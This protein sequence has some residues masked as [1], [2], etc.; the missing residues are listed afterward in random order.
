[1]KLKG[2]LKVIAGATLFV[3]GL[4]Q[5]NQFIDTSNETFAEKPN[6]Q[7]WK[8]QLEDP[9]TGELPKNIRAQELDFVSSKFPMGSRSEQL[10]WKNIGPYNIGGRTR[11]LAFDRTNPQ[12]IVAGSASG[13]IYRTED[14]GLTW[15]KVSTHEH[16]VSIS[17]IEQD[18]R[19]GKEK[20]WYA[21]TGEARGA[22][23]GAP[24]FSAHFGGDGVLISEDNGKTW[25][26]LGS[27]INDS[28]QRQ[29]S[30]D[31]TWK[32]LVDNQ[33]AQ[34]VLMLATTT[35]IYRS[36]D[37]GATWRNVSGSKQAGQEIDIAQTKSGV[38]YAYIN[39]GIGS[40]GLFRSTDGKNFNLVHALT[41]SLG[42]GIIGLNPQNE[43]A[44]Y[45][46]C[47][48][49]GTGMISEFLGRNGYHSLFKYYYRSG[50]GSGAG[51]QLI[52]L[53]QNLPK[54][55]WPFDDYHSQT[56]YCMDIKVSPHDS[57]L[58]ALSGVNLNISHDGFS[59]PNLAKF[60][61][62]YYHKVDTPF[63]QIYPNHHP[64]LQIT[65]FHPT[66][67]KVMMTGSDGGIH[68]TRD[69]YANQVVWESLNNGYV[70]TQFYTLAVDKKI[71]S[72]KVIGGLQDNGTLY[73]L[74]DEKDN[75]SMPVDYDGAYCHF[76]D[77]SPFFLAAKQ[78]AGLFKVAVNSAGKRI[79]FSRL[80]PNVP[81]NYLFINPYTIDPNNNRTLYLPN[82]N[83]LYRCVDINQFEMDN[84][85][86][87][88]N[89]G[90]DE[91]Q[92]NGLA[93]TVSAVEVSKNPSNILYL[94][95]SGSDLY[96][97][98]TANGNYSVTN[99]KIPNSS[100]F[101]SSIATHPKDG[102]K[103]VVVFSNYNVYS[104]FYSENG[105]ATWQN[106]SGD[107]EGEIQP[108]VP[109][110]FKQINNGPSCRLAKFI[111]LQDSTWLLVGTSVGLFGT[112]TIDSMNT[113][114]M[115]VGETTIG[116]NVVTAIDYRSPDGYLA[117]ATHGGGVFTASLTHSE[118]I[119]GSS[120]TD[121]IHLKLYPNPAA[122]RLNVELQKSEYAEISVYDLV[123][124]KQPVKLVVEAEKV[125][126]DVSNL[127]SGGYLVYIQQNGKSYIRRFV[128]S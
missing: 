19:A 67:K 102:N 96:R 54:G 123:G 92:I 93:G 48:T 32:I 103:L 43:N 70:T 91:I 4:F 100:G 118:F 31:Q 107:L 75:W 29:D 49:P 38:W 34:T 78:Q 109:A 117:V 18:P 57:N 58:V 40:S 51:G 97:V 27:F 26:R 47:V 50:N 73:Y 66:N 71:G 53:S 55:G 72:N 30:L 124:V 42:R 13:G 35:G 125:S 88:R 80:D 16:N 82:G 14:Q 8:M 6:V 112:L 106:I 65:V 116:T 84:Q 56:G 83:K 62:G 69:V 94:G 46:V 105:G 108:G 68:L 121:N 81:G 24:N 98:D 119:V 3:A 60:A 104:L 61:G 39:A 110:D 9:S 89:S 37:E 33:S 21:S 90:W 74:A 77:F 15:E 115:R 128:K 113:K 25:N 114:W 95:T 101:V 22:S 111:D 64:D 45:L 41:S 76:L 28:P 2:I 12:I 17:W 10:Q 20:I 87:K 59:T 120:E 127:K 7:W 5:L 1:M 36:E 86:L 11:A 79:A 52:N 85:F 99:I 44:L 122:N 23:Q 63:Y 126:L